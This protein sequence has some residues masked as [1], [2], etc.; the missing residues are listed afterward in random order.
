MNARTAKILHLSDAHFGMEGDAGD[1]TVV[2][3]AAVDAICSLQGRFDLCIFSGDLTF[4]A[5]AEEFEAGRYW[6]ARVAEAA[7]RSPVVIVPGNHDVEQAECDQLELRSAAQ[8]DLYSDWVKRL[9]DRPAKRF[10]NWRNAFSNSSAAGDLELVLDWGRSSIQSHA[11]CELGGVKVRIVGV[12]SAFLSCR[13]D[14]YGRLPLNIEALNTALES[15]DSNPEMVIV[16]VHHPLEGFLPTWNFSRVNEALRRKVRGASLLLTGHLHA[17]E[18]SSGQHGRRRAL[19]D[20][21]GWSR[22]YGSELST[23]FLRVRG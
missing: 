4:S 20:T 12:N 8:E 2:R 3:R 18:V 10:K 14:D 13:G 11:V 1:D 15:D 6:L 19:G 23:V 9:E 17:R 21:S 16:C 22:L 7:G 5:S